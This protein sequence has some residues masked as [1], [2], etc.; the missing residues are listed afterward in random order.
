ML[1]RASVRVRGHLNYYAVTDNLERCDYY[2][3]RAEHLLFKWINRKSQ[4][5]AYTWATFT[6][7]L[8]HVGWPKPRI[9]KDLCP[10]RSAEAH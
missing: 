1:R 2:V 7:A 9:H 5:K 8:A 6:Q 3:W 10:F 4:R